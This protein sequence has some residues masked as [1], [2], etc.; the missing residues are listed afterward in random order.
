MTG[1][2]EHE[3]TRRYAAR[4]AASAAPGNYRPARGC[5]SPGERAPLLSSVG[6]G[7]YLGSADPTTDQAYTAALI[8]AV[9]GGINVID[10]AINYRLQR[11]ERSIG[12]ALQELVRR[13][14]AREELFI[15]T[16][17][18][19]LTPDRSIPDNPA[20]YFQSEYF[21]P[22]VLRAEDVAGGCH[23]MSPG[24]LA[25]QLDRSL[26]NLGLDCIDVYY[27]HNPE[28]QLGDVSREE[29][30]R[31]LRA[32][33]EF[34][35]SA[36][37]DHK[38][39]FYGVATWN[40]FRQAGDAPDFLSLAEIEQ[41]ARELAGSAHHFRFVQLPFNLAMTEALTRANQP[42]PNQPANAPAVSMV[43]A[44]EALDISL[45]ASATLLQGKLAH[46]LPNF[47]A[48]ALK[49]ETDAER[50][51]Q[52][53]RSTP[54]IATALTGMSHLE[55][56][57]ANLKLMSEPLVTSEQFMRLFERGQKS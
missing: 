10:S 41:V 13:G 29:F 25:N 34:F 22:G 12:A 45:I 19:Y 54:G 1:H 20:A 52:F 24:F 30:L 2:A 8:E 46:G 21:A 31:R 51:I 18:G 3:G 33:F 6:I 48:E 44:A 40:G 56:V 11:S 43:E 4:F 23:A 53:A 28:T 26:A 38:I 9:Q 17:G 55:H 49:L 39:R 15:C 50:A 42:A 32:A 14:F 5:A 37:A 47:I 16:K 35:E 36:A 7:T 27:L 57:R